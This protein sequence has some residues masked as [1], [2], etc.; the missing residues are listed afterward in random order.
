MV[1]GI[2]QGNRRI[3]HS[4]PLSAVH[5]EGCQRIYHIAL[6]CLVEMH[7]PKLGTEALSSATD[8]S[9]RMVLELASS[10]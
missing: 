3:G 5:P 9:G 2:V 1:V 10:F 8:V 6:L 4:V 7:S